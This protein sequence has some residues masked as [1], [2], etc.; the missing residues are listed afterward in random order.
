LVD[1][2]VLRI[3]FKSRIVAEERFQNFFYHFIRGGMAGFAK[4]QQGFFLPVR[5]LES[6]CFVFYL[7]PWFF[8]FST[9]HASDFF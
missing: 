6:N 1:A 3:Y 8:S 7:P 5:N 2:D 9:G 4:I